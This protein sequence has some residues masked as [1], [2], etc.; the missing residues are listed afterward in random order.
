MVG[1]GVV[2]EFDFAVLDGAALLH[3]T[4]VAFL[5]KLDKISLS[6]SDEVRYLFGRSYAEGM[7]GFF[8]SPSVKTKK[9]APKTA[10]DLAAAFRVAVTEAAPK[11]VTPAFRNFVKALVDRGLSVVIA[12][13]AKLTDPAVAAAF[14]TLSGDGIT[15]YQEQSECYG[16]VFFDSWLRACRAAG[17]RRGET[18]AVTGGGCGVRAALR[19]GM[20]S[21]AVVGKGVA[22]QDFGGAGGVV[23][24]LSAPAARTALSLMGLK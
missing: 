10:R 3:K 20:E 22:W 16:G 8:A 12:T 13:R 23:E 11:A 2:V 9:T 7:A 14:A 17:I 1:K 4:A 15:L 19:S 6:R 21:L 18:L 5:A 24:T